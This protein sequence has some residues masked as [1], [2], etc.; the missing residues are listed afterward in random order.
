[1]G[2]G[3]GAAAQG[4]A[5]QQDQSIDGQEDGRGQ[6]F[7]EQGAEG[8]FQGQAGDAHGDGGDDHQPGEPFVGVGGNNAACGDAG[9]NRAP[10]PADDPHPV[11]SEEDDQSHCGGHVQGDD[12]RQVGA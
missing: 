9:P 6:R 10:E 12:D 4:F 11:G 7:G 8:V 2:I 1:V 5:G 3:G